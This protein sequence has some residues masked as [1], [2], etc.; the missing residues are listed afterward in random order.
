[1]QDFISRVHDILKTYLTWKNLRNGNFID[2]KALN[3]GI[4]INVKLIYLPESASLEDR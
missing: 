2:L 4:H 3:L 1:M